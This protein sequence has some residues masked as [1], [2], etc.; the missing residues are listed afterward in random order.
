MGENRAISG[1][2]SDG[3]AIERQTVGLD[4]N[5]IGIAIT[6]QYRIAEHQLVST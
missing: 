4:S 6:C 3:A 2:I 1:V 5:P